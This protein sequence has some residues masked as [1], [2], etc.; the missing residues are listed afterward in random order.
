MLSCI[1]SDQS[2]GSLKE[3]LR[4]ILPQLEEMQ[5]RKL[6]RRNQFFDVVQQVQKIRSEIYASDKIHYTSPV[7]DE[8]DL[9]LRKL[10]ELQKELQ[11]LQKEKVSNNLQIF[12]Y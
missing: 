6:E 7:V 2:H 8:T 5:K 10:E 9:S 3:E 4:T 12:C 1:Q 11:A